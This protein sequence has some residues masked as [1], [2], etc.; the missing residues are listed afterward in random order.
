MWMEQT[1]KLIIVPLSLNKCQTFCLFRSNFVM[2]LSIKVKNEE[3]GGTHKASILKIY[4]SILCP[5]EN[6]PQ[7]GE[8]V[9]SILSVR[10]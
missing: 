1:I 2:Q 9:V 5:S 4:R 10:F 6:R 8:K 3:G 7:R